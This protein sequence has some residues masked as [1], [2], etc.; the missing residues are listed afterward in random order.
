MVIPPAP[1]SRRRTIVKTRSRTAWVVAAA[2]AVATLGVVGA[3]YAAKNVTNVFRD[4][5]SASAKAVESGPAAD[6][7]R[8]GARPDSV[9]SSKPTR[10]S[11]VQPSAREIDLAKDISFSPDTDPTCKASA[12][13]VSL[14][15]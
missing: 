9:W 10:V 14:V 6:H 13:V 1:T 15:K 11:V 3:V 5:D 4:G 2:G 8:G 7:A 12:P